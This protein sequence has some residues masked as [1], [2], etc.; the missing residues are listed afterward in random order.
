MAREAPSPYLR[1]IAPLVGGL[2]GLLAGYLFFHDDGDD[3]VA[4]WLP[5]II[6]A[7]AAAI[8]G[9]ILVKPKSIDS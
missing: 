8:A 5:A 9:N 6:L 1:W 4:G 2:I 3:F 7:I